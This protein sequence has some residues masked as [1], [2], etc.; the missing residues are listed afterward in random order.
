MKDGGRKASE[1]SEVG[2]LRELGEEVLGRTEG[3][4]ENAKGR[5]EGQEKDVLERGWL[6]WLREEREALEAGRLL[7]ELRDE[8]S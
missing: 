1:D 8:M 4:L 7:G 5:N 6:A 2:Q 3:E